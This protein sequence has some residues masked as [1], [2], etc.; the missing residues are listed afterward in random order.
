MKP[1]SKSHWG[2]KL[3]AGHLVYNGK[4]K[5][6]LGELALL[7]PQCQVSERPLLPCHK[8]DGIFFYLKVPN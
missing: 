6:S 1:A 4:R 3:L 5:F 2:S 7:I 8:S